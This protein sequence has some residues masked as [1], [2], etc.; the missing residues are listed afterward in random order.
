MRYSANER[1]NRTCVATSKKK[2]IRLR[3]FEKGLERMKGKK[4]KRE[5]PICYYFAH[6]FFAVLSFPFSVL[7]LYNRD[8]V[9]TRNCTI[10][11]FFFQHDF[12]MCARARACKHTRRKT[13]THDTRK[14]TFTPRIRIYVP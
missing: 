2:E 7:H 14:G 3:P 5:H 13:L 11:F 8:V 6:V 4:R 9:V 10:F 1:N 12:D